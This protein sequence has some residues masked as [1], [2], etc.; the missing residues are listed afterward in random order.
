MPKASKSALR[1]WRLEGRQK[2]ASCIMQRDGGIQVTTDQSR[3]R[4][5]VT[6][7]VDRIGPP[8]IEAS[9]SFDPHWSVPFYSALDTGEIISSLF[10]RSAQSICP[11]QFEQACMQPRRFRCIVPSGRNSMASH[12]SLARTGTF[13]FWSSVLTPI[14]GSPTL[15]FPHDP[16]SLM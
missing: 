10:D 9:R 14:P 15:R 13:Q 1:E 6:C 2:V 5:A 8:P 7:D 16:A 4:S 11:V 3:W 12:Q